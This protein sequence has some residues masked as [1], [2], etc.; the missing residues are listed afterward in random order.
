[1]VWIITIL[2]ALLAIFS[3]IIIHELGHFFV[4]KW[5]GVKVLKFSIGFG[6]AIWSRKGKDGTEY[7]LAV[8]PLGGY[9]RMLGEDENGVD[10]AD[11]QHAF[12]RQPLR[13]RMA[14]VAAGPIMNLILA[15]LLFY[16]VFMMG[17]THIKPIVGQVRPHSIAAKA[18]LKKGDEIVKISYWHTPNWQ[19]VMMALVLHFGDKGQL[20]ITVRSKHAKQLTVLQLPLQNWQINQ[21]NPQIFTSLGFS[22]FIPSIPA[23]I[24][25]VSEDSP[26]AMAGLQ[27]NDRV[28][29]V[30]NQPIADWSA[31]L[32]KIQNSPGK[33]RQLLIQ[34][35]ARQKI[36][37]VR[38]D[39]KKVGDK[40]IG[41]LGVYSLPP[42]WPPS[43]ITKLQYNPITAWWPAVKE[44][45]RIFVFNAVVLAKMLIGKISLS[46]L[47]G[48]IT[49]ARSAGQASYAGLTVYLGFIAFI[50]ITLAF[51]NILPIPGLDGGHLFFQF[52]EAIFRR[53]LPL[54]VQM[55][56]L[57][58]GLVILIWLMLQATL[59]DILRIFQIG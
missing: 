1:M 2:T 41:F 17:V 45:T 16:F 12:S 49:I 32:A 56:L 5:S 31:L 35:D 8:L 25:K 40:Q 43:V 46:A 4:A 47:G 9:V 13:K 7:V 38:I 42:K 29:A 26:A 15:V 10:P 18:G 22:P 3:V 58:I 39:S 28:L 55:I 52:I 24:V 51:I 54:R 36:I 21:R 11:Y 30:D 53:P 6:K 20:P 33:K 57:R 14:I 44:T 48:P 59:N 37:N 34:R 27:A 19:R 23:I 50:S